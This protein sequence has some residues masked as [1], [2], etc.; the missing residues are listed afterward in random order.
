MSCTTSD[1]SE[2]MSTCNS[3]TLPPVLCQIQPP[4]T[5]TICGKRCHDEYRQC[6]RN[7]TRRDISV[8]MVLI[9]YVITI[10]VCFIAGFVVAFQPLKYSNHFSLFK[11]LFVHTDPDYNHHHH[12]RMSPLHLLKNDPCGPARKCMPKFVHESGNDMHTGET[13]TILT[14]DDDLVKSVQIPPREDVT[15]KNDGTVHYQTHTNT[16][17]PS[18]SFKDQIQKCKDSVNIIDIIESYQLEQFHRTSSDRAVAICPFHDDHHPS[19]HI[20]AAKQIY[21][22]FAC[23]AGGDVI[24]FVQEY[25]KLPINHVPKKSEL[26]FIQALQHI[27][28]KF[29]DGTTMTF[30]K[31]TH[32]STR[33]PQESIEVIQKK[34]RIFLANTYAALYFSNCLKEI[35]AGGARYYLR[36]ARGLS[37]SL[38]KTMM[39][40]YAPDMY[41]DHRFASSKGSNGPNSLVNHLLQSGFTSQEILDSGLAVMRKNHSDTSLPTKSTT[42]INDTSIGEAVWQNSSSLLMDRFRGRIMVPIIDEFGNNVLGFG[43]RI[44]PPPESNEIVAPTSTTGISFK[45]AK[46]LN[47]PESVVFEKRKILFNQ[48]L[49]NKAIRTRGKTAPV[50]PLILVEGYMDAISLC[51]IGIYNVAATMGTAISSE[52][53]DQASKAAGFRGGKI[54]LCLDNDNAGTMAVERL[55]RNGMVE[56]CIKK[57]VVSIHVARLP[58]HIKDPADYIEAQRKSG[59]T[60][61]QVAT[62]FL[63]EIVDSAVDWTEWY[64]QT[65][66]SGYDRDAPR[67]AAGSF[68]DVFERIAEFLATSLPAAERTKV[69]YEVAGRLSSILANDRNSTE[70]S[71]SVRIQLESDLIDLASR[72]SAAK[73]V[74]QR[75]IDATS[76][77]IS[78]TMSQSSATVS[79]F[80]R[81]LGPNSIGQEGKL[82]KNAT[83]ST[84]QNPSQP[85]TSTIRRGTHNDNKLNSS[86]QT[87]ESLPRRKVQKTR[88]T[89]SRIREPNFVSVTTHF[90][91]FQFR[92]QSD[93]DWLG[94]QNGKVVFI[95]IIA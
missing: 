41:Y 44:I 66:I 8:W 79:S 47:S 12:H 37:S 80:I 81:G 29:G 19:L 36:S 42:N 46:Y 93:M 32:D 10:C 54:V 15:N 63:D 43:G 71:L 2:R 70:I 13:C 88:A 20:D 38:L 51:E 89:I 33:T 67:N 9:I 87:S 55:C 58:K 48:H 82:S 6:H 86:G 16:Q 31:A 4:L 85:L 25:S 59:M 22:C 69:A 52:Q 39:I 78:T 14:K 5:F 92:H 65:L 68:S 1:D 77:D 60:V 76:T 21:K 83:K 11:Q 7:R 75:R 84:I 61:Q 24:H 95:E 17:Q 35:F 18:F 27:Q 3:N 53:L 73:E 45:A 26:S 23:N 90:S 49:A 72:L 30:S 74:L 64:I 50:P 94:L 62:I 57:N 40:G 56:E 91:G 34:E 28:Q